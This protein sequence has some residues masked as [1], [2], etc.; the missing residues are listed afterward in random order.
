[1]RRKE[2]EPDKPKVAKPV[3]WC[4]ESL[5]DELVNNWSIEIRRRA[6]FQLRKVQDGFDPDDWKPM[7]TI[8]VGVKE[9]RLQDEDKSQYRLIF[10]AKYEEG[11]YVLHVITKNAAQKTAPNDIQQARTRLKEVERVRRKK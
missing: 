6:G 4:S 5:K 2:V 10:I 11:I 3:I 1:M 8:G 9:I 7:N